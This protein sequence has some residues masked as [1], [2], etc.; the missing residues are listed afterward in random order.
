ML[1]R[2]ILLLSGLLFLFPLGLF[3]APSKPEV[4]TGTTATSAP[5]ISTDTAHTRS[6]ETVKKIF[7]QLGIDIGSETDPDLLTPIQRRS[8]DEFEWDFRLVFREDRIGLN[9]M[10]HNQNRPQ[11][12]SFSF[13]QRMDWPSRAGVG[14]TRNRL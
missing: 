11:K 6:A 5:E 7:R 2:K 9:A 12:V 4:T 10:Y 14:P 13:R 3:A 1:I 8:L